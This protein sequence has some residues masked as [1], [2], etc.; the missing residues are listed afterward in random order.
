M[1]LQDPANLV[2]LQ[3]HEGPHPE[4]YH[5]EVYRRLQDAVRRCQTVAQ[6]RSNLVESLGEIAKDVCTPG[7]KLHAWTT[8]P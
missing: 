7:S 4:E 5:R 1:D 3:G 2:Y 8:K 6:C